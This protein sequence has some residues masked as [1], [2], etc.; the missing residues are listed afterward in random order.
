MNI[1]E[2]KTQL[3]LAN[4]NFFQVLDTEGVETEW[5]KAW[6]NNSRTMVIAH[7][8]T[9]E[10]IKATP[11]TTT[12]S[13]KDEGVIQPEDTTKEPYRK[14]FLVIFENISYNF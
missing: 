6:D 14:F 9:L 7:Q 11:R 8:D 10:K 5:H 13:L 3:G 12:L 2:I 4:L 1:S